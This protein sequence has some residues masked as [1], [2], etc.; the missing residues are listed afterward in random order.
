MTVLI[1][2][3]LISGGFGSSLGVGVP[4]DKAIFDLLL[5]Y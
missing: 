1:S 2:G 4:L 3:C 5:D